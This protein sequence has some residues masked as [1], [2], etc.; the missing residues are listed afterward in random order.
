MTERGAGSTDRV[1]LGLVGCGWIAAAHL[2]AIGELA[3]RCSLVWAADPDA[4]RAGEIA[5]RAGCHT[6]T[7]YRE[8]LADVDAVIVA[9]PHHLHAPVVLDVARAGKHILVEKPLATTLEDADRMLAAAHEAGVTLMVGY[10]RHY[11]PEFRRLRGLIEGGRYGRVLTLSATMLEDVGGYVT[12]WLSRRDQLG[13]GCFFSAGGHPLEWLVSLGGAV[14]EI[15]CV[16]DRFAVAMEGEDTVAMALRFASG[17]L[18]TL[19]QCWCQPHT[20]AWMSVRAD[21]TKGVLMLDL[22]PMRGGPAVWDWDARLAVQ[23]RHEE[24]ILHDGPAG[25]EFTPQLEHFLDCLAQ[26]TEPETGGA[27]ARDLMAAI[28]QGYN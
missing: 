20:R 15:H 8:G 25:F 12:G 26:G 18:G 2:R 10:T 6:L 22:T 3:D 4:G 28:I 17:A 1:R 13:G 7:D 21:C 9:T 24:E 14:T 11:Q 16:M 23:V 5:T 19:T 27:Y